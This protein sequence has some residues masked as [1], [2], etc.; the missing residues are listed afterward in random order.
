V[1]TRRVTK[2]RATAAQDPD[3]LDRPDYLDGT[4]CTGGGPARTPEDWARATF[5][6]APRPVR[7]VLRLGWRWGLG[8]RLGPFPAR[9][10]VLGWPVL[11]DD[12]DRLV[13]GA[14][15]AVIGPCRL[16]FAVDGGRLLV[17]TAIRYE[18]R[19]S[20]PV[21]T[22]VAPVHRLLTRL[23]VTRAAR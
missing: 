8:L 17:T 13:L 5:E 16:V 21:W 15:S 6:G 2:A 22:V 19:I 20:R 1:Q 3:V 4:E 7:T 23:L 18:H 10:H 14:R 12:A 11:G 9:G